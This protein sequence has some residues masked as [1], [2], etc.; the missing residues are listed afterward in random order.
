MPLGPKASSLALIAALAGHVC[1]LVGFEWEGRLSRLERDYRTGDVTQRRQVVR[2]MANYPAEQVQSA[3][4][5]ALRDPDASVRLDAANSAGQVK[6]RPAVPILLQW[7]E[8]SD[9]DV[10][11]AAARGL[12][13]IGDLRP[14]PSLVRALGDG[15]S[16]VRR[17]ALVALAELRDPSVVVPLLARLDDDDTEV[18]VEAADALGRLNNP[19]A[20]VPLIG[21]ARD[22]SPEVRVAVYR[23]LGALHDSRATAALIQSLRDQAEAARLGA[24]RALGMLADPRAVE[25]LSELVGNRDPRTAAAAVAALGGIGSP[26]ALDRVIDAVAHTAVRQTATEVLASHPL[27]LAE[28]QAPGSDDALTT[29]LAERL[30]RAQNRHH[31]VAIASA[32]RRRLERAA[33]P[34]ASAALGDALD[35]YVGSNASSASQSGEVG[36]IEA[37]ETLLIALA[38]S[39]DRSVLV[40]I[41][42]HLR[43]SSPRMIGV[44]LSA[45]EHYFELHEPD[46]RAADPLLAILGAV[47]HEARLRV[48]VVRLLGAIGAP[49]A[50]D[51][52]RPLLEHP[53]NELR[54]AAVQAL[55]SIGDPGGAESLFELLEDADATVRFEAAI[56]LG[57]TGGT[58]MISRLVARLRN[59][60]P[61]DRHMGILALG[62]MASRLELSAP[63]QTEVLAVLRGQ[64][65][66]DD[67]E[68]AARAIDSLARWPIPASA[69]ALVSIANHQ[70][71]QRRARRNLATFRLGQLDDVPRAVLIELATN[72]VTM[73]AAMAALGEHGSAGELPRLL[74][75]IDTAPWPVPAAASFSIARMARHGRLPADS[76]PELCR[77]LSGRDAYLRANLAV[78]LSVLGATC[79]VSGE[80]AP[81]PA[82]WLASSHAGVVRLAAARWLGAIDPTSELLRGCREQEVNPHVLRACQRPELPPLDSEVDLYAYGHG[83]RDLLRG[84]LVAVRFND[85]TALVVAADANGHVRLPAAARGP[86]L[87]DDPMRTPLEP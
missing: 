81:F 12:G 6:L 37:A 64:A 33:A 57:R 32:L 19:Q 3:L 70:P 56:A 69:Q 16:T 59:L 34:S 71:G 67:E 9:A 85:G 24:I 79:E 31:A 66:G 4:L 11:T 29:R 68:L 86:V 62:A 27:T 54:L 76:A 40:R 61:F 26:E 1:L 42:E 25:P 43:S 17:A 23:A 18:R 13:R 75:A 51:A 72:R 55:G 65:Q 78:A 60:D 14:I 8:D 15:S 41:L 38:I 7:L 28:D 30:A 73:G 35:T 53:D 52:I 46:G 48:R 36:R 10:R 21:R 74:E 50:L 63:A 80:P 49:R 2:L 82:S 47:R 44:S 87:L 45:L 39:G 20:V 5:L 83:G 84:Q 77:R 58:P 22:P